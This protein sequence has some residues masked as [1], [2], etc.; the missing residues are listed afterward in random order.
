MM[1]KEAERLTDLAEQSNGDPPGLLGE[2]MGLRKTLKRRRWIDL[3]WRLG[4]LI[5]LVIALARIDSILSAR[6]ASR[7]AICSG[8]QAY[9]TAL[10]SQATNADHTRV[11]AFTDE[12]NQQLAPLGCHITAP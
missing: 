2:M 11:A 9:T 8:F 5:P 6:S 10:V 12:L 3:A 1:P 4:L 7:Q